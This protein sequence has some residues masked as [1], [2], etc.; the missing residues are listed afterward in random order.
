MSRIV[1]G[2][3]YRSADPR[4]GPTVRVKAWRPGDARAHVVDAHTGKRHRQILAHTLHA[5]ATTRNGEP[6][7]TGYVLAQDTL[8]PAEQ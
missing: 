5:T 1:P 4:G 8:Q 7:R 2:Q 3:V 6:R